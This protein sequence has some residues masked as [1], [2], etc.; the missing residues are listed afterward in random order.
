MKRPRLKNK[1]NK[2][3]DPT[4]IGNHKKQWNYVANLNKEIKLKYFSKYESNGNKQFW[5]N[6]KPYFANK[7]SK[8]DTDIMLSKNGELILKSKEIANTFNNHF[9]SIVGLDCWDGHSLSPRKGSD[10]IDNII[11]PYKNHPSIKNI[12][13]KFNSIRSFS[14]QPVFM[15]KVKTVTRDMK[16]NRYVGGEISIQI[17]KESE[18]T[19]EILTNC[20][21]KSIEIGCF[22]DNLKEA[23]ITPIFKKN[24]PPHK[25]NYKPISI[26]P[27]ISK[28]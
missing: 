12:K 14:F 18:L 24:H 1:A 9:E 11:K 28:E 16:N 4:D 3:K 5:G 2:A 17:L 6:C 22:P 23:N 27:L 8:A 10:R 26:L 7:R 13:A 19:F 20:I 21:N 15:D 25:S